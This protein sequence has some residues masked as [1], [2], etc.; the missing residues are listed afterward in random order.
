MSTDSRLRR[1]LVLGGGVLG[2]AAGLGGLANADDGAQAPSPDVPLPPAVIDSVAGV[3]GSE[4]VGYVD[5][6][7]PGGRGLNPPQAVE[8]VLDALPEDAGVEEVRLSSAPASALDPALPWVD[9]HIDAD[10]TK[11]GNA[12]ALTWVASVVQGA[13]ADLMRGGESA[14]NEVVGGSRVFIHTPSGVDPLDGGGPA[15]SVVATVPDDA[16]VTW[17]I[18]DLRAAITGAPIAYEGVLITLL[19][20]DQGP[21]VVSGVSYRKGIGGVWFTSG[22]DDR[23]GVLHGSAPHG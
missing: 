2:L 17:T 3:D 23:F 19:D 10:S 20:E 22:G 11:D 8:Q 7:E 16:T 12:V 13:V 14:T 6:R 5:A 4:P 21:L 18:D 9:I 15:V 1:R